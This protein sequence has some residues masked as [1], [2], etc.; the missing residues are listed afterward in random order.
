MRK[1]FALRLNIWDIATYIDFRDNGESSDPKLCVFLLFNSEDEA[2]EYAAKLYSDNTIYNY[3]TLYQMQLNDDDILD[4]SGFEN[5]E[6]FEE[7][8]RDVYPADITTIC[9][10]VPFGYDEKNRLAR[11][12]CDR[13]E[14][15]GEVECANCDINKSID[16]SIVVVWHW[17]RYVGYARKFVE[18]RYA[19]FGETEAILA[20]DDTLCGDKIDIV[21]TMDEVKSCKDL[22]SALINCLLTVDW[23][24]TNVSDVERAIETL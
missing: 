20:K 3:A 4:V 5:I 15:L 19:H 11:Y 16:G 22:K 6:D 8:M 10:Y 17:H 18:L 2:K 7:A 23:R 9:N 14:E 21:M 12:I 1:L 13:G 24:W